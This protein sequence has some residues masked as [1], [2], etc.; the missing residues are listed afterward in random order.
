MII[1]YFQVS[2]LGA[3]FSGAEMIYNYERLL[4]QVTYTNHKPA[5]YLNRQFK[6]AC[7]ELNGRFISNEYVQTVRRLIL[8]L[9]YYVI[10]IIM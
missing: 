7:S 4:R 10:M 6:I 2:L 8:L 5:Y 9:L 1:I 3:E